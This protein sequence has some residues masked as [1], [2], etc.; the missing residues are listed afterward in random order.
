MAFAS[1]SGVRVAVVPEQ[2]FGTIPS[3]PTFE[4]I[5]TTNGGLRTNKSTGTSNERQSHR[6]VLDE[7]ELGQDVSGSYDF[8]LTYGTF[9]KI[10]EGLMFNAWAG[11]VL[12]NGI[13]P[14]SFTFEET[15]ELGTTDTYRR[16]AGCMINTM[17]LNI[18]ARAAVTGSFGIMGKQETLGTAALGGATYPAATTTPVT[19]ASANVAS[20]I[21]GDFSPQPVVRSVTLEISNNLRTRPAV[22]TKYSAEFGAGRF[23]V[24]GTIE[25]YFENNALYQ[26]ILDH[27]LASL[28]FVVGVDD[29][30]TFDILNL[31]LGDGN[32]TAGGNDDDIMVS[33]PFRGLLN[34][35]DDCTLSITREPAGT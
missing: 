2:S 35:D 8:E 30:Y 23:D 12:V 22:G 1:G 9:D 10:L 15:Y 17:S 29:T 27:G 33:I 3:S 25:A 13:T 24:T 34:D 20:L 14:K 31:R 16:F 5:R 6:N 32:V 28:S 26:A 19:T 18:G 7:Y 21:V 11:N 4:T